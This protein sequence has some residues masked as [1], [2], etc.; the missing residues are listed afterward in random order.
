MWD[1]QIGDW[2]FTVLEAAAGGASR[3]E[4]AKGAASNSHWTDP[5]VHLVFFLHGAL[6]LLP[7]E[8]RHATSAPTY[9]HL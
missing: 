4:A 2:R 1:V 8:V 3:V 7:D 9:L 6:G 5:F